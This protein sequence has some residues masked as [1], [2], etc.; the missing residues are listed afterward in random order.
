ME[1]VKNNINTYLFKII[2]IQKTYKNKNVTEKKCSKK[3]FLENNFPSQLFK[4]YKVVFNHSI[5][6][7][8]P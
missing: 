6:K 5:L 8:S 3:H 7:P 1:S 4:Y 2:T